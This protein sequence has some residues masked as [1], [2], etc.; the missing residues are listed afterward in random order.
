MDQEP[1]PTH[2]L[3]HQLAPHLHSATTMEGFQTLVEVTRTNTLQGYQTLKEVLWLG[4]DQELQ[5]PV[6]YH[7][8]QRPH[9]PPQPKATTPG[10]Q[11]SQEDLEPLL[12]LV[13][14]CQWPRG[15]AHTDR[16][17]SLST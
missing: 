13:K 5:P 2:T 7:H 12:H 6:N 11:S 17:E 14:P 15:W 8:H 10:S 3:H 4:L 16:L 1:L 9:L